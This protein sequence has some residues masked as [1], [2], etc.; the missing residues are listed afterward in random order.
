[1]SHDPLCELQISSS[2]EPMERTMQDTKSKFQ[3]G[4]LLTD[5]WAQQVGTHPEDRK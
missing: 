4:G 3:A 1:M 2:L 5:S